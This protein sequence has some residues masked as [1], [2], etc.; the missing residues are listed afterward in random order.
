MVLITAG[1]SVSQPGGWT[2]IGVELGSVAKAWY[3]VRQSGDG[4]SYTF[5]NCD[6]WIIGCWFNVNGSNPIVDDDFALHT[7]GVNIPLP[8][9]TASGVAGDAAI[10]LI[11]GDSTSTYTTAANYLERLDTGNS[12]TAGDRLGLTA[13]QATSGTVVSTGGDNSVV[14]HLIARS[15]NGRKWLL[16]AH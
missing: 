8:S 5:T 9:L 4:A 13:S 1:T 6:F 11:T 7:A 15:T 2:Q 12:Q 14:L 10:Y 3:R 16:G